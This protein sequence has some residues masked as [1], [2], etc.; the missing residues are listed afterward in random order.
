[1]VLF[2]MTSCSLA[3][4]IVTLKKIPERELIQWLKNS[5]VYE[6]SYVSTMQKVKFSC[7]SG[8]YFHRKIGVIFSSIK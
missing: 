5:R 1:M 3:S 2:E 6:C 7:N 8:V 4:M